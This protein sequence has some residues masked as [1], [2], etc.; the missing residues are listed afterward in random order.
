[1]GSAFVLVTGLVLS[2]H[3]VKF[4]Y[5]HVC[6]PTFPYLHMYSLFLMQLFAIQCVGMEEHVQMAVVFVH[7]AG[8]EIIV[9]KVRKTLPH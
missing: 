2:V 5:V 1:M 7:Q 4:A 3:K 9:R 6:V 8:R